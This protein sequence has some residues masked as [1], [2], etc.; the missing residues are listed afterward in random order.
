MYVTFCRIVRHI[1]M[2]QLLFLLL[3][4]AAP[5]GAQTFFPIKKG[6]VLEYKYY[7]AKG[8]PLRNAWRNERFLRFTV[9]ETWGDSIANVAIESD[10]LERALGITELKSAAAN[11]NYGDVSVTEDA[12]TFE[13]MQWIFPALPAFFDNFY[14]GGEVESIYKAELSATSRLP[15]ELKIGDVL[16][17]EEYHAL[18]TEEPIDDSEEEDEDKE[19]MYFLMER[20]LDWPTK[21]DISVDAVVRNRRVEAFERVKVRAGEWECW[22]ISYE[23]VG[24]MEKIVGMP[25]KEEMEAAGLYMNF[26]S[27]VT[28]IIK[29]IDYISPEVGLVKRDKFNFRGNK[30]EET[31][32]LTVI[33]D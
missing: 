11:I 18:F 24:P 2:K 17:D 29:Y 6:V 26:N 23:V 13:N 20:G 5:V 1:N 22:K 14:E 8:K 33:N 27:E 12:L 15:K 7:N 21:A 31:M 16:P 3:L 25:T 28:T 32:E 9:E 4:T 10:G 19:F 30:V